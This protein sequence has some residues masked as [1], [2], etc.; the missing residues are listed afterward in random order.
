MPLYHFATTDLPGDTIAPE[1]DGRNTAA[2]LRADAP[3]TGE[4]VSAGS[5]NTDILGN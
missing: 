2:F 1:I 3:F 5:A 4:D